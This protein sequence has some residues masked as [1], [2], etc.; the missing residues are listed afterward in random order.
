M[1]N[2]NISTKLKS[3]Q[4]YCRKLSGKNLFTTEDIHTLRTRTR[5]VLSL[6]QK[7][8]DLSKVLKKIIKLSNEIR[9]IDVFYSVFFE[10]L[11]K[12]YKKSI[13]K[14]TLKDKL[15]LLREQQSQ[16]LR[17]YLQE[18]N[19]SELSIL[20]STSKNSEIPMQQSCPLTLSQQELHKYRIYIKTKFYYLKNSIE[21]DK[22]KFKIYS[23]I[24]NYLG[25]I[26]DNFN[27]KDRITPFVQDKEQLQA[28]HL[29]IDTENNNY[30]QTVLKLSQTI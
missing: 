14:K 29:Y 10:F 22:E 24:K 16:E 13:D 5:E 28:L 23:Q 3:L 11:P 19:F 30:F 18:S 17:I 27:A 15:S 6:L 1:D 8:T 26:N 25:K 7:G 4:R 21:A 20:Y 2:L 12:K 9:D